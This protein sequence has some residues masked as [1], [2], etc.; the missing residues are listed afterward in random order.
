MSVWVSHRKYLAADG[1]NAD[2]CDG[3]F[4]YEEETTLRL[5][6]RCDMCGFQAAVPFKVLHRDDR[7]VGV[8]VQLQ[9]AQRLIDDE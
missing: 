2:I 4:A 8:E 9:E 5:V 1:G 6:C 7:L 3:N